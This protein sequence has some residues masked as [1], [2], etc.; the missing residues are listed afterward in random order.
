MAAKP[1]KAPVPNNAQSIDF[2][3]VLYVI[4]TKLWLIAIFV[5]VSLVLGI[6]FIFITPKVYEATTI[7]QVDQSD[8]KVVNMQSVDEQDN[9]E[10]AVLKTIEGG[11]QRVSLL[12]RVLKRPEFKNDPVVGGIVASLDHLDDPDNYRNLHSLESSI[13][14]QLRRDTRLIDIAVDTTDPRTSMN[15]ANGLV[16]EFIREQVEQHSG[17]SG[18]AN[19][20][21]DQEAQRLQK[22]LAITEKELDQ[23]KGLDEIH[24]RITE[25][26]K[27]IDDLKQRY[28]EQHPRLIQAKALLLDLENQ[29]MTELK[30]KDPTI[31]ADPKTEEDYRAVLSDQASRYAVLQRDLASDQAIYASIIQ[32]QKETSITKNV[33]TASVRQVEKADLPIVPVWPRKL[34]I[35]A[36]AIALGGVTGLAC[37][38]FLNSVDSSFRQADDAET[39]LQL[40]IM[41]AIPKFEPGRQ[42]SSVIP[43]LPA[44][45]PGKRAERS[46]KVD[47]VLHHFPSSLAAEA[48][49]SLRAAMKLIGRQNERRTFL[50]S[51]ALPAEGKSFTCANFAVSLAQEGNKTLLVDADLRRPV[52]HHIFQKEEL[53]PGLTE[54]LSGQKGLNELIRETHIPNLYLL[55]AGSMAPSPAELLS[56]SAFQEMLDEALLVFDR[57]V[58]DSAPIHAVSD[59]L[60]ICEKIQTTCMVVRAGRTPRAVVR[61]A[62]LALKMAGANL[63]GFVLNFLPKRSGLGYDQFYYY[64]QSTEKYGEAYGAGKRK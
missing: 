56:N 49:R 19:E 32:R 9:K 1:P 63:S 31:Q 13:R 43:D 53:N 47:L 4:T 17:A 33:D 23:S 11:L 38:F 57:I 52:I 14:V 20:F 54:Y 59:T 15:I 28:L 10:D 48:F 42:E 26:Q 60:L 40:P 6:G 34:L 41:G 50:F 58:I 35:I 51:S 64:Y 22:K 37:A 44:V 3:Q 12:T 30:E 2:H 5:L 18:T 45:K 7:V 39:Y 46:I 24:T 36:V 61:K 29:F 55:L 16:E 21:L 8:Q 25:Q 27:I 62:V